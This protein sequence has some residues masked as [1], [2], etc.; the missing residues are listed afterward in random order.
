MKSKKFESS[1]VKVERLYEVQ[2]E[3]CG[4]P[5]ADFFS[6]RQEA[7]D[8]RVTHIKHHREEGS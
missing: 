7:E 8:A 3:E 4:N 5:F 1:K 2:C 6:S